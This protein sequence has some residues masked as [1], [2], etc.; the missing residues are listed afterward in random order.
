MTLK[1]V[2]TYGSNTALGLYIMVPQLIAYKG[3]TISLSVYAKT[4]G[5]SSYTMTAWAF[6][7]I[8]NSSLL[9]F[10]SVS[11]SMYSPPTTSVNG[12]TLNVNAVGLTSSTTLASATGYFNFLTILFTIKSS[13]VGKIAS[14]S[15][16][17]TQLVAQSGATFVPTDSQSTTQVLFADLRAGWNVAGQLQVGSP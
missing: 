7:L 2:V 10:N 11:S 6:S 1:P 17:T 16:T 9:T 5:S 15:S 12:N 13:A 3:D 4:V 14:F 8:F